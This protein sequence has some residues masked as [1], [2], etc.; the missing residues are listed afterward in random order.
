MKYINGILTCENIA[1]YVFLLLTY[2]S[3]NNT[4]EIFLKDKKMKAE[5]MDNSVSVNLVNSLSILFWLQSLGERSE[6]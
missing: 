5:I 1:K 4:K 6:S 2:K 3:V